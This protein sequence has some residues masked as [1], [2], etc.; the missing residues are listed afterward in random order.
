MK[1]TQRWKQ[2]LKHKIVGRSKDGTRHKR[3]GRKRI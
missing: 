1:K 2:K 3:F